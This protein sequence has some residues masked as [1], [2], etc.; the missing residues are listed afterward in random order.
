MSNTPKSRTWTV[1][2]SASAGLL[3]GAAA[4][5]GVSASWAGP[6]PAPAAEPVQLALTDQRP[7]TS[8]DPAAGTVSAADIW[9]PAKAHSAA[10][11]LFTSARDL[12]GD[13]QVESFSIQSVQ[14]VADPVSVQSAASASW[15]S[16]ASVQSIQSPAS[17]QSVQS[18]ASWD[19][20]DSPDSPDSWDSPD[21]VDSPDW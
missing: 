12:A 16:P 5:G 4:V 17:V 10:N 18:P 7:V 9:T 8:V 3:V 2:V 15:D 13:Q 6:A 19:S 1:A 20:P 14:S 11:D 21:S